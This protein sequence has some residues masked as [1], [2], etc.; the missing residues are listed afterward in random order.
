MVSDQ[1]FYQTKGSPMII[2]F[3]LA[4]F[5]PIIVVASMDQA[6]ANGMMLLTAGIVPL[7]NFFADTREGKLGLWAIWT[8]FYYLIAINM[9]LTQLGHPLVGE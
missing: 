1:F 8:I 5:L 3:I 7:I 2:V 4:Y 6:V 9:V